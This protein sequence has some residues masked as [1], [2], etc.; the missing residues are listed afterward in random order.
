MKLCDRCQKR[1]A[2]FYQ[3]IRI[4]GECTT[5]NLCPECAMDVNTNPFNFITDAFSD[6]YDLQNEFDKYAEP[7][8]KVKSPKRCKCG[9]TRDDIIS[10]GKFGCSECY[11]TF[12]D[13]VEEYVNS[14]GGKTYAGKMPEHV[15]IKNNF[16][17]EE[18]IKRLTKLKE[19]AAMID[20]FDAAS[21]YKT[22]II[23]LQ[24]KLN[25]GEVK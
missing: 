15:D 7:V 17:I 9:A 21:K 14:L 4:N 25:N 3:K 12:S 19:Q 23:E 1:E 2:K 16:S 13:L 11:K 5:L 8:N 18:E 10:T 6:F 20:D 22:Q 24:K